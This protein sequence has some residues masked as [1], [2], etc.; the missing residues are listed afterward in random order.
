MLFRSLKKESILRFILKCDSIEQTNFDNRFSHRRDN[1]PFEV[2]AWMNLI[3]L[4]RT[5]VTMPT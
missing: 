5:S 1:N 3:S 4:S 2:E